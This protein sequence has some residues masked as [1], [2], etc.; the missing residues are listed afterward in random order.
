MREHLYMP[1]IVL[2]YWVGSGRAQNGT[3]L[4]PSRRHSGSSNEDTKARYDGLYRASGLRHI[5]GRSRRRRFRRRLARR[6]LALGAA[7]RQPT[8]PRHLTTQRR[9]WKALPPWCL[10]LHGMTP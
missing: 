2:C 4:R 6:A 5:R 7:K 9:R 8:T 10:H 1:R 3:K